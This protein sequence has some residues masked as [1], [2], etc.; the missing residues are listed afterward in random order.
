MK[1]ETDMTVCISYSFQYRYE[2]H[3][4]NQYVRAA[5]MYT[6]M[7]VCSCTKYVGDLFS[8]KLKRDQLLNR[9]VEKLLRRVPRC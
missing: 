1:E 8:I 2:N 6:I 7:T 4:C 9:K 5:V 3:L